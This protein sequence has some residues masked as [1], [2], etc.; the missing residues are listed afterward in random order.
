[1][2]QKSRKQGSK[3]EDNG[4]NMKRHASL[5][6]MFCLS[7]IV[8]GSPLPASEWDARTLQGA[9]Q[10]IVDYF[11]RLPRSYYDEYRDTLNMFEARKTYL[12]PNDTRE[13]IVDIG[14]AY[15][16]IRD[17]LDDLEQRLTLTYFKREDGSKV[18]AFSEYY[19][20]GD[21]DY[22]EMNFYNYDD[23]LWENIT[24][25]VLPELEFLDFWDCDTT[26][27]FERYIVLDDNIQWNY[28]LP[29]YGTTIAVSVEPLAELICFEFRESVDF[30]TGDEL[31]RF[32]D[33]YYGTVRARPYQIVELQWNRKI[34]V[35]EISKQ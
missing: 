23:Y 17:N 6:V 10:D 11:L 25:Q 35:F 24:D 28:E 12:I 20:G 16:Q 21:C 15:L 8:L 3:R 29:R 34:G 27:F 22:Y 7:V 32:I 4:G 14:N 19:M 1:M 30:E 5:L 31:S 2:R 9:P 18:I 13:V 33:E 26:F